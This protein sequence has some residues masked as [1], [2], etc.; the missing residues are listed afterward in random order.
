MA[1]PVG[2][3]HTAGSVR[4]VGGDGARVA[5]RPAN[6]YYLEDNMDIT[7]IIAMAVSMLVAWAM[8]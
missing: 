6:T 4:P 1:V 2:V 7:P 8:W 3:I 5:H